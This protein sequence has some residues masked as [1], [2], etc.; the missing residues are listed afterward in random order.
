MKR[1]G[2]S[3][4][5]P[6]LVP[7]HAQH[8]YTFPADGISLVH[9]EYDRGRP[10]GVLN[11]VW[12]GSD[13]PRGSGP[14]A[15]YRALE[16]LADTSNTQLPFL[17]ARYDPDNWAM[18]LFP[19]N[20]P[21]RDKLD[22]LANLLG[23]TDR[24]G[25]VTCTEQGFAAFLYSLR[26]RLLPPAASLARWGHK[27][28]STDRWKRYDDVDDF[29][30]AMADQDQGPHLGSRM[31]ARRRLYQTHD[32]PYS[33]LVPCMDLDLVLVGDRSGTVSLVVDYKQDN[34]NVVVT[35]TNAQAMG[36]LRSIYGEGHRDVPALVVTYASLAPGSA[37]GFKV[38]SLNG[39]GWNLLSFVLGHYNGST[40][41]LAQAVAG[42]GF[43]PVTEHQWLALLGEA[44]AV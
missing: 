43:V 30:D 18:K 27:G 22:A 2:Y 11:Y 12:R 42:E 39:T 15:T 16:H 32:M 23:T 34:A 41:Q 5:D 29:T 13:L 28:W 24:F 36:G 38:H 21:A 17:T 35:G 31:S 44:K 14:L 6:D 40:E 25:W 7:F 26:G 9:V 33:K 20:Q 37:R 4:Q 3:W 10:V 8:G 1:L 19:H